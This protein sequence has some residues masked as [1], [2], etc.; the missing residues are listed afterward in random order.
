MDQIGVLRPDRGR[1]DA[2]G[3]PLR[4]LLKHVLML[5]VGL[6]L[7]APR[8]LAQDREELPRDDTQI[9]NE[10]QAAA[11]VGRNLDWIT[12]GMIRFGNNVSDLIYER[13]F[14][15]ASFRAGRH[16]S[17]ASYYGYYALQPS[18][19]RDIREHRLSLDGTVR[20]SLG[21]FLLSDRNR[22]ERRFFAS[23]ARAN[24]YRNRLQIEHPL[25]VGRWS[26]RLFISDEV[27][28]EAALNCWA[29]NRFSAGAGYPIGKRFELEIYYLKQNDGYVR[30]GNLN[31]IGTNFRIS[32]F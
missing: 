3:R 15:G 28:Y 32:I 18:E 11:K 2:A 14:S 30:P 20:W 29:R 13:F 1:P 22:F 7:S 21:R 23:G 9:W 10:V 4:H 19:H 12:S 27:Y 24:R 26:A 31:V 16:F 6:A 17:A 5:A 25:E 8:V